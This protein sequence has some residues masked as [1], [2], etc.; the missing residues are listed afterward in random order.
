[1]V[2]TISPIS[3]AASRVAYF[4]KDGYYAKDDPEHQRA[5]RWFGKGSEE[6]GLTN[7]VTADAFEK[8]MDGQ[9]FGTDITLG[10]TRDGK[11]E[12]RPGVDITFSAPKSVSIEALIFDQKDIVKCHDA[13]VRSSLEL[14]QETALTTRAYDPATKRMERQVNPSMVAA[15]FRHDTS[16]NL[17]PQ[18]HTHCLVAN[19]TKGEDGKWRSL[20]MGGLRAQ[21]KFIGAY[22]RNELAAGLRE[23]GYDINPD[24]AGQILSFSIGEHKQETL[25]A[26]STRRQDILAWLKENNMSYNTRNAQKAAL[27]TRSA[28]VEISRE[29]LAADWQ[30]RAR[31]MGL[32]K[33]ESVHSEKTRDERAPE[34]SLMGDAFRSI[35]HLEERQPVFPKRDLLGAMLGRSAGRFK[36]GEITA[37]LDALVND[38]HLLPGKLTHSREAFVSERTLSAERGVLKF[39]KEGVGQARAIEPDGFEHD[40]LPKNLTDDQRDALSHL[41]TSEDRV[42]GIEGRAGT[43]KTTMLAALP[44]FHRSENYI[45]LAPSASAAQVLGREAGMPARTLAWFNTKYSNVDTPAKEL[46]GARI[47]LDEASMVSTVDM[48]TLMH[49]VKR[50]EVEQLVLIGDT[51][52]LRAVQAGQPFRQLQMAG[53]ETA[54]MDEIIRQNDPDLKMA[55]EYVLEGN[56]SAA[57]SKL[58]EGDQRV[59]ESNHMAKDAADIWLNMGGPD[60]ENT[61]VLAQTHAMREEINDH[62]RDGLREDGQL[63][64]NEITLM[65]LTN[66]HL[67]RSELAES[68]SY[69]P[70]DWLVFNS[71]QPPYRIKAGDHYT[72]TGYKEGEDGNEKILLEGR[73]GEER[74]INPDSSIRYRFAL[75]EATELNVAEGDTLKWTRNDKELG[76]FNG[77]E[78][79]VEKINRKTIT[80]IDHSDGEKRLK[81]P[82]DAVALSHLDHGY[83]KTVHSAQGSTADHVIAVLDSGYESGLGRMTDQSAFYVEISRA[84]ESAVVLTDNIEELTN[85]LER[86]TGAELTGLEF[87]GE[88]SEP[89]KEIEAPSL[90]ITKLELAIEIEDPSLDITEPELAIE[91][92]TPQLGM[93]ENIAEPVIETINEERQQEYLE[94]GNEITVENT[95]LAILN[96]PAMEIGINLTEHDAVQAR[97]PT[98]DPFQGYGNMMGN[99]RRV[100]DDDRGFELGV[101]EFAASVELL[102]QDEIVDTLGLNREEFEAREAEILDGNPL[103]EYEN[104]MGN[105]KDVGDDDRC[106]EY[107]LEINEQ[108]LEIEEKDIA[109]DYEL[110]I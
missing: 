81:L 23:L 85:T 70:G 4:Q 11:R 19:M 62:I 14:I 58:H 37:T 83:C 93:A 71:D 28:K 27:A 56:I 35:S 96:E 6:L 39:Y 2:A 61:I 79:F 21:M 17:D 68:K 59:V 86:N 55:V 67:T 22:Y 74:F 47:I 53:M 89:E 69:N 48:K 1:M 102:W 5:S 9:V 18:L 109:D 10:R 64:T 25:D 57:L 75:Y 77:A 29:E 63:G 49:L 46:N 31:G 51:K 76:V 103:Q 15:T 33:T 42:V 54:Q 107:E 106:E 97:I 43:G 88:L 13:A 99:H 87:V 105:H 80:L 90:D 30:S 104:M 50:H 84:R 44:H 66:T 16:R 34:T 36:Y 41:L 95:E 101:G 12:H 20:D 45:A 110:E 108:E 26:F 32:E 72:V 7:Q 65:R 24:K 40:T 8:I 60:R 91:T 82:L 100:G 3:S 52:Q 73:N 98:D 38:G 92:E 78:V 94:Y